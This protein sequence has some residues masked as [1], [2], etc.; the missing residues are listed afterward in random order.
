MTKTFLLE[1][2]T[3]ELPANFARLALAQIEQRVIRDLAKAR[4][5][6]GVISTYGT[7]RRL[8]V[9]V[10]VLEDRQSDLREERKGPPVAQAFKNGVPSAAAI[11]FAKRCGIDPSEL[12]RRETPKGSFVFATSSIPGRDGAVLLQDLIPSW[13]DALQGS[14]FMRWGGGTRRFSRPIRWLLALHG[15]DVIEMV[16]P[17]TDPVVRS[18][19]FSRGHR[20]HGNQPLR[21]GTADQYVSTL[22]S[23]GVLVNRD[24]R[25]H[26]IRQ[27]ITRGADVV[28]GSANCPEWL[29]EELVD[30]VEN[31]RVL[32][33]RISGRF[34]QLPP[35]VITTVMQAHQR[36]VPL[37]I[38][39]L[40]SDPLRLT[41]QEVL[42]PEFLLVADG[43]EQASALITR[44]NERVLGARLADAEFFLD[45]DRHQSSAA[46]RDAL[47]RVTFAEG[48]GSLQDR[49]DRIER[50][51]EQLLTQLRLPTSVAKASCRAAHFCKHDLVSQMVS[52]F[53][54]LQGLMGGKYLLE[55][56]ELRDVA[57]A[58]VE[59]YLPRGTGDALPSTD[60]GAVV[61]LA[62]R[63]E[64]LLSIYA[65]G[66]RP[67][68]SSDPYA[69]RRAGNGVLL[70]LWHQ[71]WKL[72][73]NLFLIKAVRL[74]KKL[75][76]SFSVD[77]IQLTADLATLLRQR[78]NSQLEDDGYA[79]D[80]IQAVAGETVM[81]SRLL[82]DPLDV[83]ER[84]RL[85]GGLR[86]QGK[87][88]AVQ[89][90]VQR[91]A[92]LAGK[93]CLPTDVLSC[94]DVVD[95][96]KFKSPSEQGLFDV[97]RQLQPLANCR[98]Y[99]ELCDVLV[100]STPALE[101]FFNSVM[102]MADDPVLRANRLNLLG[103][104][105]NQASVL[106][107]FELIQN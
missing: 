86:D 8:A 76:P 52:E 44:G 99:K 61:A 66:E 22:R 32:Q 75:F 45:I 104:L 91:V 71:Q 30:L 80:L 83:Q 103:V 40:K 100:N 4:L 58:V 101:A 23:A 33:G 11:G 14:R 29:F 1:I 20:L 74:W 82:N 5:N 79:T 95:P 53:P 62:E 2:G 87:L 42:R 59:H 28:N 81:N 96:S 67:S 106:A 47:A 50:L 102:V 69:L 97:T 27:A 94:V 39:S 65:K 31:P 21:I 49:C 7:P 60:A 48:L 78:I 90:A 12:E 89:A 15:S 72:D 17:G 88:A 16:I 6:H 68:G 63:F 46:R 64:L 9:S 54:E 38:P 105:R 34:L 37:E 84:I 57:L 36:Y 19:R 3:E 93:G 25:S 41:A 56:G 98:A 13:I 10:A 35:E 85:L 107:Q 77:T 92:R 26:L 24:K 18:D 51:T 43:L 70:I 55:E 73:L